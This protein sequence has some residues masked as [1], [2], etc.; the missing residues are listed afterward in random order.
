MNKLLVLIFFLLLICVPGLTQDHS[1]ARKWNEVLL[2][3]IRN[4]LARPTVH[5]RNLFHISAAIYDGWS[6]YEPLGKTY[7]LGNNVGG[8]EIE[9]EGIVFNKS[10]KTF[11]QEQSISY[12]AY[13]LLLHR[14][15]LSPGFDVTKNLADSLMDTLGYDKNFFD[16]NYQ[17]GNAAALGNYIASRVITFG[18]SDGSNEIDGYANLYYEPLNEPLPLIT[19]G[20]NYL[21]DPNR[22]QPL[23]FDQSFVDQS[24]NEIK[25]GII[26]FLSPEWG[27]VIPFSYDETDISAYLREDVTYQVYEDPGPPPYLDSTNNISIDDPYKW[28]FALVSVWSA[29]LDVNDGIMMDISPNAIGNIEVDDF[30]SQYSDLDTFYDLIDGG[31]ISKGYSLNPVTNEPYPVQMVP[32]ADYARVLAEFWADGPDSET[33][34]GHW[35]TLLNYVNDHPQFEKKFMGR[36][37]V[38]DDLQWDVISYFILGGAMHDAAVAAWSVKGYYD[39]IRPISAIRY[40]ATKGQST[41]QELPNYDPSGIPLI[42]GYIELIKEGD[43]LAG[44]QNEYVDEIKLYAWK[45]HDFIDDA[46]TDTAGVGWILAEGW[47]PYQRP[48]FVTPPFAGYVSGHSTFSRAAAEVMT[49]LT[50]S[51]YFPGGVGEFV[52]KQND[53]LV[54]ERGP[55]IDV[56]LQWAKYYDA[57]DQCSLSRIWGG[58]HPPADDIPGR[59]MGAVIGKQAFNYGIQFIGR[60]LLSDENFIKEDA[61][62]VYP[63]PANE[64]I[65]IDG[66][67]V[68]D[69]VRITNLLGQVIFEGKYLT[70]GLDIRQLNTGVYVA[71]TDK[72]HAI[73]FVVSE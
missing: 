11:K 1:V 16:Q 65:L 70:N 53:F 31:D 57:S 7:F 69:L 5:A 21:S 17:D 35:F 15:R 47:W 67:N 23:E 18:L 40:M 2:E 4:D 55:S 63:N 19:G 33:P 56:V 26:E 28:G 64:Y 12:A 43:E 32:R 48:S 54:F 8:F 60:S 62:K 51:E 61:L 72:N 73:R 45:G 71:T 49:L 46:E 37:R 42:D 50:G 59:K 29:H 44:S 68:G 25:E 27:N 10:E 24:G 20:Q 39:Y 14:F 34:P 41:N 22:W 6:A 36:G 3:A 38:V 13:R 9:Y 66:I 52:A 58:I 30:P